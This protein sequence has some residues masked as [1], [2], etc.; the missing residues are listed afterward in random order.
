M[1]QTS[2]R[3]T[4]RYVYKDLD[5]FRHTYP[6]GHHAWETQLSWYVSSWLERFNSPVR[7]CLDTLFAEHW[8]EPALLKEIAA[9]N[10]FAAERLN[11]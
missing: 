2:I 10:S 4:V 1:Y 11:E 5:A 8:P 3:F 9:E 7:A 6:R